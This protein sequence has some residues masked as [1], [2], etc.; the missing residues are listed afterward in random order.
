LHHSFLFLLYLCFNLFQ[1]QMSKVRAVCVLK[2]EGVSGTVVI[3]QDVKGGPA[4]ITGKITG[5]KPGQ[6]GF[7]I[8]QFGDLSDGC[9]SAGAHFNPFGKVHGGP[10]DEERHVGDLG[11][12]EADEHGNVSIDITDHLV[13]L[14]G[15]NSV[16]G[17][18][19]IIHQDID[20]LGKTS[21]A[22][23]KTTGNAGARTAC[24]VIGI[25]Q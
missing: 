1:I 23:S 13:S 4:H 20:D 24:G 14:I 8:H 9:N 21:H 19:F 6:H 7:H 25:A 18:A 22:N 11:N 10:K 12:V 17:R 15:S 5:M 2:G 16:I 3:E